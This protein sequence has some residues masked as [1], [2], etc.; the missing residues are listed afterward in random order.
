MAR[1]K[2]GKW[3]VGAMTN[4]E[5][6]TVTVNPAD[7][8]TAGKWEMTSY[9]DDPAVDTKTH[10]AVKKQT[11]IVKVSKKGLTAKPIVLD[12][13]AKGGAAMHFI[14]SNKK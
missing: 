11:V 1:E 13:Q 14:P 10:V 8:L 2:D 9:T 5:A 6:R 4:D 12:L 3:Y 7:F